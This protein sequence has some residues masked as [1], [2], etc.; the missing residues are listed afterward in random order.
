MLQMALK[1]AGVCLPIPALAWAMLPIN[2]FMPPPFGIG[3]G[4][5]L[6]PLGMIYMSLGFGMLDLSVLEVGMDLEMSEELK[7]QLLAAPNLNPPEQVCTDEARKAFE[8]SNPANKAK[9]NSKNTP[10]P[11]S[12]EV[13]MAKLIHNLNHEPPPKESLNDFVN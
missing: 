12:T 5:P 13:M 6:T 7:L 9:A 10:P 11:S 8:D 2:I 3:I 4:P 1:I